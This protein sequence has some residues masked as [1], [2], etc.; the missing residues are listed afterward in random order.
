MPDVMGNVSRNFAAIYAPIGLILGGDGK[1]RRLVAW[2]HQV[3]S[4]KVVF[5]QSLVGCAY[6]TTVIDRHIVAIY[7]LTA[8]LYDSP[9]CPPTPTCWPVME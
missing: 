7:S 8:L 1:L 4:D 2:R 3:V 5:G 6:N 9:S